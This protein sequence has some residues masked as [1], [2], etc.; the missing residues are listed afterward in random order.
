MSTARAATLLDKQIAKL[1]AE[2]RGMKKKQGDLE[3]LKAARE[4]LGDCDTPTKPARSTSARAGKGLA[5]DTSADPG[6]PGVCDKRAMGGCDGSVSE[7]ECEAD[8]CSFTARR[9]VAHGGEVNVRRCLGQ[10]R[11]KCVAGAA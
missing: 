1:E 3:R 5:V 6:E 8:G 10:H 4:L 2:L 11:R 9:C 7:L